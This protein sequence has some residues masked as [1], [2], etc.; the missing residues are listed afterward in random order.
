MYGV[1][2][3]MGTTPGRFLGRRRRDRGGPRMGYAEGLG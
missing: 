1:S 2:H 3:P